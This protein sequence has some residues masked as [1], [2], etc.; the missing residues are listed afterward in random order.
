M[1]FYFEII[2]IGIFACVIFDLWQRIFL[3]L[4][5][6]PP[7]NWSLVGR[8]VI[9]LCNKHV[10]FV[11]HINEIKEY[12]YE[13]IAGWSLHYIVAICYSAIYAILMELDIV[14]VGFVDGMIFG[15]LSVVVPWFFFLPALGNGVLAKR[16]PKPILIC[17]LA[18]MMHTIFGISIGMGYLVFDKF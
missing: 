13:T 3:F 10:I 18:L 7:S 14:N 1:F 12:K 6:I 8:W 5:T 4:T 2:I 15:F 16:A 11:N 17:S 9:N